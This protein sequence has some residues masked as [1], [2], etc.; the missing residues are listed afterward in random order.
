MEGEVYS[1]KAEQRKTTYEPPACD[2]K[3]LLAVIQTVWPSFANEN[4]IR[5]IMGLMFCFTAAD[6]TLVFS[7]CFAQLLATFWAAGDQFSAGQEWVISL[8]MI[9]VLSGVSV[10]LGRCFMEHVG[11][12]WANNVRLEGMKGI[13]RQPR[14][15]FDEPDNSASHISERLDRHAEGME[16]LVSRFVPITAMVVVMVTISMTWALFISWKLKLVALSSFP[17]IITASTALPVGSTKWEEVCNQGTAETVSFM[18]ET[19]INMRAVRAFTLEKYFSGR[20]AQLVESTC[21]LRLQRGLYLSP[22]SGLS[23]SIN[24]F[25]AAFVGWYGM[26]LTAQ[27]L[28]MSD[29]SL[30][31]VANLLYFCVGQAAA[32]MGMMP[33]VSASQAVATQVLFLATISEPR[34]LPKDSFQRLTSLF[35]ITMRDVVFAHP[36][37]PT[38][39]ILRGVNLNIDNGKCVA[40]VKPSRCGKSTDIPL[41]MKLYGPRHL[42]STCGTKSGQL[43]YGDTTPDQIDRE[44]FYSHICFVPQTTYHFPATVADNMAYRLAEASPLRHSSNA[45]RAAREAGTHNLIVSLP[46]DHDTLAGN[47]GQ[48]LSGGQSQRD[49]IARALAQRPRLMIIDGPTCAIDTLSAEKIRQTITNIMISAEDRGISIVVATHSTEMIRSARH[50]IVMEAGRVVGESTFHELQIYIKAFSTLANHDL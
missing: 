32:F 17:V 25:V 26:Y 45:R 47:G 4:R 10:F 5:L 44:Q 12:A 30:Q 18:H 23:K 31:Q 43:T 29:N 1:C 15:W 3:S 35:P 22:L 39:Q 28:E 13:L 21:R 46:Q 34:S 27:E 37:Q 2:A 48:S 8:A 24:F 14:S 16:N 50:I 19:L 41:L 40:I 20:H 7:F 6:C 42:D 38:R 49:C 11:K 36:S 9:T 33:L